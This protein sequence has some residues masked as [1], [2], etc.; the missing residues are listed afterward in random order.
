MYSKLEYIL[1]S[2]DFGAKGYIL[3]ETSSE[4]LIECINKVLDGEIYIDS[5]ISNKVIKSLVKKD[6]MQ[7]S[8]TSNLYGTLTLREQEILRLL[9]ESVSIKQI[10]EELFISTKTVENHKSSILLKLNCRNM[11]ELVRYAINIGLIDV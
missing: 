3:K 9:V 10:A 11:V 2:L 1:E 4:K 7:Y 5:Y 8:E 6:D